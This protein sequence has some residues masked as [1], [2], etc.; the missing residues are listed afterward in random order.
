MTGSAGGR[1][2]ADGS[3]GPRPQIRAL[4]EWGRDLAECL[5][6]GV[7]LVDDGVVVLAN[8][9]VERMSGRPRDDIEGA[10]LEVLLPHGLPRSPLKPVPGVGWQGVLSLRHGD[11]SAHPV[12]VTLSALDVGRRTI[13]LVTL[14]DVVGPGAGEAEWA[15]LTRILDLVPDGVVV[16]D[17][18]TGRVEDV[19]DAATA[20]LRATAD[21]LRGMPVSLLAAPDPPALPERPDPEA[22]RHDPASKVLLSDGRPLHLQRLLARDG[23]VVDCEVHA[24]KVDDPSGRPLLVNV[25]RDVGQRLELERRLRESEASFRTTFEQAPVGVAVV[26]H[27]D[28]GSA[29]FVQTNPALDEM[30]GYPD[31]ELVGLDPAVLDPDEGESGTGPLAG[32]ADRDGALARTTV[33]RYRRSDGSLVWAEVRASAL[34]LPSSDGRLVLV[35]VVDVTRRVARER[36]LRFDAV[37]DRCVG[38]VSRIALEGR[39]EKEVLDRIVAGTLEVLDAD[40]A[41]V[42]LASTADLSDRAWAATAGPSAGALTAFLDHPGAERMLRTAAGRRTVLSGGLTRTG[43]RGSAPAV[44]P[45]ALAPFGRGASSVHGVVAACRVPDAAPFTRDDALRLRR[46]VFRSRVAVDLARARADQQRLALLDER[47]RIARDLHDTVI[48]DVIAVG[49]QLN[50][51]VASETD[52]QRRARDLD[53]VSQ[54]EAVTRNLR[55]AVFELRTAPHRSSLAA[56]V[57]KVLGEAARMLGHFPAVTFS[58]PVDE[59]PADVAD[60]LVATLREAL[61]N[62]ARHARASRSAV[63]LCV[64][65]GSVTLTV[66]DDGVG[67]GSRPRTGDGLGN[68][69]QR[70]RR[71]GGHVAVGAAPVIGTRLVWTCPLAADADPPDRDDPG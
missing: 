43:S 8:A 67:L 60:D 11:G 18:A 26:L 36:S 47:Q 34:D 4:P 38:D 50:A 66:D 10:P 27:H 13:T 57:T 51:D 5:P 33:R 61:A 7:L 31:G 37:V 41:A 29:T 53:L 55:R 35:H 52:H 62:V 20:L 32:A 2:R 64:D 9:A 19:N 22:D 39:A 65:A 59:L 23:S 1:P 21:E 71:H 17:L 25:V 24:S 45:L 56:D 28:D 30:F 6:D 15:R 69:E 40:G 44:G 48:Q 63:S 49:M 42:L 54:L 68:V 3:S 46:L 12:E 58:G 14:R 16:V 70:A